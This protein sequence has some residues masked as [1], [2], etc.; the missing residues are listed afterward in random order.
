VGRLV[1]AVLGLT[2]VLCLAGPTHGLE[3]AEPGSA[4]RC[5]VRPV[6]LA[7]PAYMVVDA[8]VRGNRLLLP[9]YTNG[10]REIDLQ[11]GADLRSV[12]PMGTKRG[13]VT[14]PQHLGC[15]GGRCVVFG[16]RYFWIYYSED[17][18]FI[19]EIPGMTTG[20][21]SQPLVF[22]DRMVVAGTANP[23]VSGG[24]VPFLF[25]QYDDGSVV[26]LQEHPQ[27]MTIPEIAK[28]IH[29]CG[30]TAGGVERLADGGWIYVDPRSYGVFVFDRTDRLVR[31]W[32]GANPRFRAPNFAVYELVHDASG[33]ESFSRWSLAQTQVKRP[34]ALGDDLVGIVVGIP[35]G[36]LRQ[37]HELDLYRLDGS[38][39]A[40]GIGLPGIEGGR[41]VVADA[42]PGRLVVVGQESWEPGSKTTAWQV[43]LTGLD[44]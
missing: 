42:G 40:T 32:R 23:S 16:D 13:Q 44:N 31:A 37:R 17:F 28:R 3:P 14:G 30:P 18:E 6:A 5:E 43:T 1:T 2:G 34:V 36:E 15:G 39:V 27:G 26:P 11:T 20:A 9:D 35:D 38:P 10:L 33:R 7:E 29:F 24:G 4:I 21:G 12:L 22:A 41:M 8:V 25:V 19:D